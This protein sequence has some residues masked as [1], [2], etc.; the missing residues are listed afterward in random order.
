M[1]SNGVPISSKSKLTLFN[2]S[3][4]F[5]KKIIIVFGCGGER[6]KKKRI[7]MGKIARRYCSKIFVTDDNPRNEDPKKIRKKIIKG[8]E[9]L[10]IDIPNRKK[11]IETAITR[12]NAN[13]VLLVAGK[14][15]EKTQDYGN[16]I[17]K[18]SDVEV[19]KNI[20]RKNILNKKNIY[21]D[22][23]ENINYQG[24]CINSKNIKK[25][26]LF[27]A[28]KGKNKDGHKFI[29]ESLNKGAIKCVVS[30]KNE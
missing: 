12:L 2:K 27:F 21:S 29:K 25:N 22:S 9:K 13:E 28:I 8:C 20:V 4:L 19:I 30:K 3:K 18:F 16:R 17:I 5:K 15:H 14:G 7:L 24:V 11:A 1:K 26:N 10:A 6:D 23:F